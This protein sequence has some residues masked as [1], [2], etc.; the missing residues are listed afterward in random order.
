MVTQ[1]ME[2]VKTPNV[3]LCIQT[4][5]LGIGQNSPTGDRRGARNMVGET[6]GLDTQDLHRRDG[7]LRSANGGG[8]VLVLVRVR[9]QD[10][11]NPQLGHPNE[12]DAEVG[13]RHVLQP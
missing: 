6:G 2:A 8:V 3:A 9:V 1:L 12:K 10:H 5:N 4:K 11:D 7:L 13:L